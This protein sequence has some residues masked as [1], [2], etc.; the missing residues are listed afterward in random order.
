MDSASIPFLLFGLFVIAGVSYAFGRMIYGRVKYGSWTGSM[1]EGRI[2]RTIGE[3]ELDSGRGWSRKLIVHEMRSIDVDQRF[4]GVVI[5]GKAATSSS[6][7]ALK[8]TNGQALELA[9]IL[10][11]VAM[12]KLPNQP[13]DENGEPALPSRK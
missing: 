5:V 1:L 9:R 6:M 8:L 2:E 10:T 13:I 4:V 7:E 11:E 3:M 12:P